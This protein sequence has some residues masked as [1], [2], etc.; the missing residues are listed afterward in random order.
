MSRSKNED[1]LG[2][3]D[4]GP[5]R[6]VGLRW[7][8]GP[9]TETETGSDD[10]RTFATRGWVSSGLGEEVR[11]SNRANKGQNERVCVLDAGKERSLVEVE[12]VSTVWRRSSCCC[13]SRLIGGGRIK[14]RTK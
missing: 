13:L 1:E 8:G 6:K 2:V 7:C 11:R 10:G 5:W 14:E 3:G 4:V 9:E 12:V